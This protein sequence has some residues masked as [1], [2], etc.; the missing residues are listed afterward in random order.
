[1]YPLFTDLLSDYM[2]VRVATKRDPNSVP[3]R[4][5][6]EIARDALNKHFGIVTC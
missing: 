3:I 5:A 4:V 1:M 2:D 6:F